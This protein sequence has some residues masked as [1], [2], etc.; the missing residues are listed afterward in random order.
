VREWGLLNAWQR[1]LK[2]PIT[3]ADLAIR[4]APGS[5]AYGGMLQTIADRFHSDV[6]RAPDPRPQLVQEARALIGKGTAPSK[7]AETAAP[8]ALSPGEEL[9]QRAIEQAK[10]EGNDKRSSLGVTQPAAEPPA[11]TSAPYKVLN[12]PPA[13]PAETQA[14]ST[15]PAK[16]AAA[17]AMTVAAPP[18]AGFGEKGATDKAGTRFALAGAAATKAKAPID[19]A[20]PPAA[21]QKCR[22][23]TASYGG[24]KSIIIR[25]MAADQVVNFTVLD[26]NVGAETREAEAF[27]AAYARNGK[28]TGEYPN[29]AQAL[30]KAFEL[31][32]EG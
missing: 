15:A 19:T 27:I 32:P 11:A 25:S 2:R 31:C 21:N 3:Y 10:A 7:V 24:Q 18:K 6:C 28:I 5:R 16:S 1:S 8:P 29:Q 20:T 17:D 13:P 22:V 26:V 23:W 14:P 4:W 9:A 30:D 12:P